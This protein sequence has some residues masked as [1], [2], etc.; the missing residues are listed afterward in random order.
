MSASTPLREDQHR[1]RAERHRKV[2]AALLDAGDEWAAVPLFYA[3]Y[4]LVKA[5]LLR[6]P[7][8][9]DPTSLSR[10]SADLT[11]EDRFVTR[12]HGRRR[13]GEPREWGV[14]EVV[15]VLYRRATKSY[16]ALHQ[17]SILVRYGEGLPANSL[18]SLRA[19]LDHIEALD[20]DGD[21]VAPIPS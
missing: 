7:I 10:I 21:L 5:A 4:H 14:N 8:F 9:G 19:A 16:E 15:Q 18:E 1:S 12:H 11:P 3:G 13:R 2:G 6:D 17:A 20:A